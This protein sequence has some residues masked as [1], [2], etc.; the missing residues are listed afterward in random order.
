[1]SVKEYE[2]KTGKEAKNRQV[3]IW[4]QQGLDIPK[5]SVSNGV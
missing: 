3:E 1:M 2:E 4:K 5:Q